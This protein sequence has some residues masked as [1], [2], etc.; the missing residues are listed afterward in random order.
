M[1][2]GRASSAGT[3]EVSVIGGAWEYLQLKETIKGEERLV[4]SEKRQNG[5]NGLIYCLPTNCK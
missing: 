5:R 2:Q 3:C 1:L 4:L